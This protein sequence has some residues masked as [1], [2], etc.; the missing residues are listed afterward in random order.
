M[1]DTV[2]TAITI[3]VPPRQV[4]DAIMDAH[5]L[6][7]WV[8]IHVKLEDAPEGE[9]QPG[10]TFTQR[11][12]LTGVPFKVR[13]T[14]DEADS[15]T[16]ARWTGDGPMGSKAHVRYEL[17][18]RGDSTCFRYVNE[19]EPPPFIRGPIAKIIERGPARREAKRSLADLKKLLEG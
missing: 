16:F 5:R 7:D 18:P 13:W 14:V 6:A 8:H 19:F 15:P 4:W 9:L 3:D 1:S 2:E 11:L 17:E 12:R 10:S